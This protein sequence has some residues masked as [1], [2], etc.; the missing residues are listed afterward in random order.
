[1][2][3]YCASIF[4]TVKSAIIHRSDAISSVASTGERMGISAPW[5]YLPIQYLLV[6]QLLGSSLSRNVSTK[7]KT[8]PKQEFSTKE[9]PFLIEHTLYSGPP[10][11]ALA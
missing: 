10:T 2:S 11:V 8:H 6:E 1:M 4:H 7:I 3:I 5:C 9:W